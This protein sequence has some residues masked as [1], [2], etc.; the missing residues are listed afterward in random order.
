M[1]RRIRHSRVWIMRY[2]CRAS[3]IQHSAPV[4][5]T[6]TASPA[7]RRINRGNRFR[8]LRFLKWRRSWN[9][10]R[11]YRNKIP[12]TYP[13]THIPPIPRQRLFMRFSANLY[14]FLVCRT[15]KSHSWKTHTVQSTFAA[16][17]ALLA[18]SIAAGIDK[19][20]ALAHTPEKRSIYANYKL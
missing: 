13:A 10:Y 7:L 3:H 4:S 8:L 14:S 1:K 11:I 12:E 20:N 5:S 18:A 16:V 6:D 2:Y 9:E 19:Y 15:R 17:G